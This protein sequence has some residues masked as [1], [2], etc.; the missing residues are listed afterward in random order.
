MKTGGDG[1]KNA[2]DQDKTKL[3]EV[4]QSGNKSTKVLFLL[5]TA[6]VKSPKVNHVF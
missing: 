6:M 5:W 3:P 4:C 1:N 2:K